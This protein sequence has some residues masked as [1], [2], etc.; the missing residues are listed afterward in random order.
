MHPVVVYCGECKSKCRRVD[1]N[2]MKMGVDAYW[3]GRGDGQVKVCDVCENKQNKQ[4]DGDGDE[5]VGIS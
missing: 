2:G 5:A 1:L 3:L 4:N